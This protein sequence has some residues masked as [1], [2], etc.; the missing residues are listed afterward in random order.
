MKRSIPAGYETVS[1][2][3][4]IGYLHAHIEL[5]VNDGWQ[6]TFFFGEPFGAHFGSRPSSWRVWLSDPLRETLS[7]L[8]SSVISVDGK[9]LNTVNAQDILREN[10]TIDLPAGLGKHGWRLRQAH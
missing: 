8:G 9:K 2:N 5:V 3:Q 6:L 10:R 4:Y 1:T 7:A